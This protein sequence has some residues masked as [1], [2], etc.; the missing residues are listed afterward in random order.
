MLTDARRKQMDY[1]VR[2]IVAH[3]MELLF[4]VMDEH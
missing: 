4:M 1:F 2:R 3:C